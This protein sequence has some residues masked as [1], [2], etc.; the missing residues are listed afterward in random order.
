MIEGE[1]EENTHMH[2]GSITFNLGHEF[3]RDTVRADGLNLC[4]GISKAPKFIFVKISVLPPTA[5]NQTHEGN[6]LKR[7]GSSHCLTTLTCSYRGAESNVAKL[8]SCGTG[9]SISV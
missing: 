3:Y 7:I 5:K 1:D 6:V 4:Q 8:V 9:S 2:D